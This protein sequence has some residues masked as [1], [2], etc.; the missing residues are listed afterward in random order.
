M[1]SVICEPRSSACKVLM[2]LFSYNQFDGLIIQVISCTRSENVLKGSSATRQYH[3]HWGKNNWPCWN[4][5]QCLEECIDVAKE[6]RNTVL[7]TAWEVQRKRQSPQS[8][9][10]YRSSKRRA[11][12]STSK[13]SNLIRLWVMGSCSIPNHPWIGCSACV[14]VWCWDQKYPM[15]LGRCFLNTAFTSWADAL[16]VLFYF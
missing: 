5:A 10:L 2:C 14:G 6:K 4:L 12:Y 1:W 16:A 8:I 3:Q 15:T 9:E 11:K 7:W 13:A